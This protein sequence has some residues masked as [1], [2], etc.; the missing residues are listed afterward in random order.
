[1]VLWP[2][3]GKDLDDLAI[4][5]DDKGGAD[6]AHVGPAVHL[7]L[8]PGTILLGNFVLGVAQEG[9]G[10]VVFALEL[11]VGFD[12]V[13]ADTQYNVLLRGAHLHPCARHSAE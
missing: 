5:V 7:F 2:D 11:V 6:D 3:L 9:E 4:S 10:E 12:A 13:G 8:T 1:M